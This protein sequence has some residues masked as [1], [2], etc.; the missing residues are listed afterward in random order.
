MP[1]FLLCFSYSEKSYH[2]KEW[3]LKFKEDAHTNEKRQDQR[4]LPVPPALN[5]QPSNKGAKNNLKK[6]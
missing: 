5:N 2:I 3:A 6:Q 4:P 1:Q